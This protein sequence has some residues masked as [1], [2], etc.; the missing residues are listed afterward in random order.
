MNFLPLPGPDCDVVKKIIELGFYDH[1]EI[2]E[3]HEYVDRCLDILQSA[4]KCISE[5]RR[6][7]SAME[8]SKNN[9]IADNVRNEGNAFYHNRKWM[10]AL[11]LFNNTICYGKPDSA[12]LAKGYANR[13]ALLFEMKYYKQCLEDIDKAL[14][15]VSYTSDQRR[16]LIDRQK[17]A[18]KLL[19]KQELK[20]FH[21]EI[22][23]LS[24]VNPDIT[25]ASLSVKIQKNDKY[26]RFIEATRDIEGGEIIA[27]ERPYAIAIK[28]KK[29]KMYCSECAEFSLN[30]IPCLKCS[31]VMYC[32]EICRDKA[33]KDY[34]EYE[35]VVIRYYDD[36]F[37]EH[38]LGWVALRSA[39]KGLKEYKNFDKPRS[40][41][42]VYRSNRYKEIFE[43]DSFNKGM[44][45][46]VIMELAFN[47]AKIFHVLKNK[48]DLIQ[49]YK[50]TEK[51]LKFL[52]LKE[53]LTNAL[54]S[55]P[56]QVYTP[57]A[58]CVGKSVGAGVYAFGSLF[59][60][61]CVENVDIFS[62]GAV[63]VYKAVKKIRKGE[64]C[65]INY[66]MPYQMMKKSDRQEKLKIRYQF[67]CDCRACANNWPMMGE[68]KL[69]GKLQMT[70]LSTSDP[71]LA[72]KLVRLLL[73]VEGKNKITDKNREDVLKEVFEVLDMLRFQEP[74]N[75][76]LVLY[77]ILSVAMRY[78]NV[79]YEDY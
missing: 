7:D 38:P 70:D 29:K 52:L 50:I 34:H 67:T 25:A 31:T 20:Y 62:Y 57:E 58:E 27:I 72:V 63:Q 59:N 33:F 28:E 65:F 3:P 44:S 78:G 64:Q 55:L 40:Y 46:T 47:I 49:K 73:L 23:E 11:I 35:C 56:I 13:S 30:L 66:G 12:Q 37:M 36:G 48:T 18:K 21:K 43:L 74:T 6:S 26:G 5:L 22:P 53:K 10:N 4:P 39:L 32:D 69:T 71:M 79:L 2:K 8:Q 61:S 75:I 45:Q 54:N 60:H 19:P 42:N 17:E 51:D 1:L 76:H 24:S 15:I 9:T 16:K 41:Q 14:N 77:D 68:G